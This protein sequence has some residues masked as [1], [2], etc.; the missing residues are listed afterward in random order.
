MSFGRHDAGGEKFMPVDMRKKKHCKG[1]L[2]AAVHGSVFRVWR[3]GDL[4]WL[5]DTRL[6]LSCRASCGDGPSRAA[7]PAVDHEIAKSRC[8]T[9]HASSHPASLLLQQTISP[10]RRP[11]SPDHARHT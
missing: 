1:R 2:P 8:F 10:F 3:W 6:L 7:G 5:L 4:D 11:T 9:L